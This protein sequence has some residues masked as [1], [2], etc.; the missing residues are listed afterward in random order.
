VIDD[1][2]GL[3]IRRV[4]VG[5]PFKG[6]VDP[7]TGTMSDRHKER[8][9]ALID[10]FEERGCLV[11]NAHRREKWGEEF[12]TPEECS[13]LDH[14][15][16]EG[17]DLFVAFPGSPASPGTHVEIGWATAMRRP[18]VL[19]LEA[20]RDYAYLVTGLPAWA[21]VEIITYEGELGFL[22]GLGPAI[23]R[24]LARSRQVEPI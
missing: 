7:A 13:R 15:E 2:H 20:G 6:W 8:Y 12:L 18:T 21:D 24:V 3:G 9:R 4:F 10:Y 16:I 22:P 17:S 14:Q 1:L 19:L 11:H 23:A 5:G